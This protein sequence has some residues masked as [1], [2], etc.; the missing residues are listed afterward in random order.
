MS[1]QN[2]ALRHGGGCLQ[3]ISVNKRRPLLAVRTRAAEAEEIDTMTVRHCRPGGA[4]M[5]VSVFVR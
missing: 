3:R 2:T 1:L 5:R 4:G